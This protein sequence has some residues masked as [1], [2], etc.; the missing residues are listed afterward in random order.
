MALLKVVRCREV[1]FDCEGVVSAAT[2]TEVLNQVA[3]HAKTVHNVRDITDDLVKK[4]KSVMRDESDDLLRT[5]VRLKAK[6]GKEKE[7]KDLLRNLIKPSRQE[8]GC[9][10]YELLVNKDNPGEFTFVEKWKDDNA[11]NEHF[12]TEHIK[13]ALKKLPELLAEDMDLRKYYSLG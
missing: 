5:V 11:L 8:P 10:S 13:A 1:G 4:V 9:I 3:E 12:E 6:Q 7:L 2:E